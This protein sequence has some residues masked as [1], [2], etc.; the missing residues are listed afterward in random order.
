M[1]SMKFSIQSSYINNLNLNS[2][3]G[4]AHIDVSSL[5]AGIYFVEVRTEKGAVRK[6]VMKM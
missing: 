6:K 1:E 5:H 2:A 3:Q 4:D